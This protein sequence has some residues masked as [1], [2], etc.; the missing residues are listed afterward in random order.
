MLAKSGVL[1]EQISKN[2][3]SGLHQAV[4]MVQSIVETKR[5]SRSSEIFAARIPRKLSQL[6]APLR[7]GAV[8][9][10]A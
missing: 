3:Q 5:A 6:T 10:L 9:R 8:L 2:M 4:I 1:S 7:I